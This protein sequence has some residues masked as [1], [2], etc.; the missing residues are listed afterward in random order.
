MMGIYHPYYKF[1]NVFCPTKNAFAPKFNY[2]LN[3]FPLT[4]CFSILF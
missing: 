3:D 2:F 4:F 1:A